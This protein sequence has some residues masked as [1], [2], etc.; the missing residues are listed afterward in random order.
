[1]AAA[2]GL[3]EARSV[4][5][6]SQEVTEEYA[7]L[8]SHIRNKKQEEERLLKHLAESTGNLEQILSVE[9]E[10][11][12]VRGEVEQMEGRLRVLANLTALA[13]VNL[14][15]EENKDY[16]PPQAP[17]YGN[18]VALAFDDSMSQF[19][20][21]GQNLSIAAIYAAPW[22]GVLVALGLLMLLAIKLLVA[23]FRRRRRKVSPFGA[24][25]AT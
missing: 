23:A 16:V 13:T 17:T 19:T 10:L 12:R 5:S 3:G 18:R 8:E 11:S 24:A 25:G 15:V 4:R 20:A 22:L 7:D 6:D 2:S 9:R 21:F 1:L 14:S